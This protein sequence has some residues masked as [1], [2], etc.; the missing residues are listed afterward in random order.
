MPRFQPYCTTALRRGGKKWVCESRSAP[1]VTAMLRKASS[2]ECA[3]AI[4][5]SVESNKVL[6]SRPWKVVS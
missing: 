4:L 5:A 2:L 3:A 6:R 1:R